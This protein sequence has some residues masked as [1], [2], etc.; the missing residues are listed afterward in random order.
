MAESGSWKKI[1]IHTAAGCDGNPDPAVGLRCFVMAITRAS[2][3]A[4][5]LP[6]PTIAWSCKPPSLL[7]TI[8]IARVR[9]NHTPE[10][11]AALREAFVASRD[12]NRNQGNLF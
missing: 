5:S 10:Q 2:R 6:P 4:G 8:E 11:L 7:L 1:T 3:L 9:R 12:P